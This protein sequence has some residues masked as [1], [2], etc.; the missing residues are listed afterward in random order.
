M[1]GETEHKP[2]WCDFFPKCWILTNAL[3]VNGVEK[4]GS[5]NEGTWLY[6]QI[7]NASSLKISLLLLLILFYLE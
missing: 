7:V 5:D 1:C 2:K 4:L 3:R 6:R